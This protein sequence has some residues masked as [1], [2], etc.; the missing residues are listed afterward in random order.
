[1]DR[2]SVPLPLSLSLPA[3]VSSVLTCNIHAI[4][5]LNEALSTGERV[6]GQWSSN[7]GIHSEVNFSAATQRT[8]ISGIRAD[9]HIGVLLKRKHQRNEI[10]VSIRCVVGDR[11]PIRGISTYGEGDRVGDRIRG[12]HSHQYYEAT[13]L[14]GGQQLDR[15]TQRGI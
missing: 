6:A 7:P 14:D 8:Q 1:M 2:R 4:T 5:F 12:R 9:L 15:L 13:R 11:V 3:S 10:V